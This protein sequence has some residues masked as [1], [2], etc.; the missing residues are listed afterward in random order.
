MGYKYAN[1]AEMF[2]GFDRHAV[3]KEAANIFESAAADGDSVATL[4]E[5]QLRSSAMSLLLT[6][7]AMGEYTYAAFLASVI[8]MADM[9]GDDDA[10]TSEEEDEELNDLLQAC[11]DAFVSAGADPANVSS[12]I[13]DENDDAGATLGEYLSAKMENVTLPDDEIISNYASS[14]DLV[15]ESTFKVIR[16]GV[17]T[18]KKKRIGHKP[19]L[20]SLQK[21]SLKKARSRAFTGA[22]KAARKKSMRIRRRMGL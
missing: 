10:E 11:A 17:I 19:R 5:G 8:E 18:L 12:F 3:K 21:A 22:A 13:E 9:D 20:N 14:G 2:A 15:L 4:A 7:V 16:N 6:W 1:E